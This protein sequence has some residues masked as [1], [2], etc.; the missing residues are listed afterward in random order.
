MFVSAKRSVGSIP[1]TK[2]DL[3]FFG[4][5]IERDKDIFKSRDPSSY[6]KFEKKQ[7]KN[8]RDYNKRRRGPRA[9][10]RT[11]TVEP[12]EVTAETLEDQKEKVRNLFRENEGG[13]AVGETR[14]NIGEISKLISLSVGLLRGFFPK[15]LK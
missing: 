10:M 14:E 5:A 4:K 11:D 2:C 7:K 13:L 6:K 1:L 9:E 12:I 3:L 8:Q 15:R